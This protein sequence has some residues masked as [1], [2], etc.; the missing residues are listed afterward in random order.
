ML[1][2]EFAFTD[3]EYG[4]CD[5]KYFVISAGEAMEIYTSKAE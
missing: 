5:C 4:D 2:F 3:D 1:H